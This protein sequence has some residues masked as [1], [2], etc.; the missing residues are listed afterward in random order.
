[1]SLR[2]IKYFKG[3]AFNANVW[4]DRNPYLKS[5]EIGY[6]L[7]NGIVTGGKV[8]PGLWNDLGFIGE[9]FYQHIEDVTNPIGDATGNLQG[10]KVVDILN[11]MLSPY[12]TPEF[13]NIKNDVGG[14]Y[15]NINYR[16][17]GQTISSVSVIYNLYNQQ[18]LSGATPINITAGGVFSNEGNFADSGNITMSLAA[19]L[20]PTLPQIIT[21]VLKATHTNGITSGIDA[22]T[23]ILFRPRIMWLNSSTATI[24]SGVQFMGLSGRKSV[25]S[26]DFEE[27]EYEFDG[28]GYMWIAI[29]AMLA[30]SASMTFSNVTNPDAPSPIDMSSKITLSINNGTGTYSYVLFRSEY[31]LFDA[32]KLKI[33]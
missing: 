15:N 13:T 10:M 30:P 11:M 17:I 23:Q 27:T 3:P 32:T 24:S 29:P 22:T 2:I 9:D 1:M 26:S 16:E 31:Y 4:S 18:N 14:T 5:G 25:L 7:E 8:G 20:T 21:L 6:L 19:P 33:S 12:E 28:S